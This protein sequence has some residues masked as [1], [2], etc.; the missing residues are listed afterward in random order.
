[1]GS[2]EHGTKFQ[3]SWRAGNFWTS[4]ATTT[5]P[6]KIVSWDCLVSYLKGAFAF[7]PCGNL[8]AFTLLWV[9]YFAKLNPLVSTSLNRKRRNDRLYIYMSL[10]LNWNK[11]NK[12]AQVLAVIKNFKIV[13]VV[14]YSLSSEYF[15]GRIHKRKWRTKFI[16]ES[17]TLHRPER[18]S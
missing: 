17:E 11:R 18:D 16:S 1:M 14:I 5:F 13:C 10:S 9:K 15:G 8:L 2:C 12:L 6:R 4:W 3:T 7:V